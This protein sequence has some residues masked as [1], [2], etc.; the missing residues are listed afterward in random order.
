[1]QF[2]IRENSTTKRTNKKY[3]SFKHKTKQNIG[4]PKTNRYNL[5]PVAYR[6]FVMFGAN[7]LIAVTS[8]AL[9]CSLIRWSSAMIVL[10][11]CNDCLSH[12]FLNELGCTCKNATYGTKPISAI[13]WPLLI[14]SKIAE[15]NMVVCQYS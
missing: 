9:T 2:N 3:F 11:I 7:T 13:G 5:S 12:L 10:A 1:M 8:P 14:S 6:G 15:L 4:L